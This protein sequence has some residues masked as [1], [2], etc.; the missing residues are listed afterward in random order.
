MSMC[1]YACMLSL[2]IRVDTHV[3]IHVRSCEFTRAG[4]YLG[5]V[6]RACGSRLGSEVYG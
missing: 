6:L 3:Q 2:C 1:V 4:L 5:S